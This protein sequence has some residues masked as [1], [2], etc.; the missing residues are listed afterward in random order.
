MLRVMDYPLWVR[1]HVKLS[2]ANLYVAHGETY[3]RGT[4][5]T[6]ARSYPAVHELVAIITHLSSQ[7]QSDKSITDFT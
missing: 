4:R 2:M 3:R 1:R 6:P 5:A 7:H